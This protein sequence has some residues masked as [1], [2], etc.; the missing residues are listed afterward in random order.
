MVPSRGG[1]CLDQI[2]SGGNCKVS[3][4]TKGAQTVGCLGDLLG[5]TYYPTYMGDY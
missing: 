3:Q 4:G 5:M 1:E 2:G